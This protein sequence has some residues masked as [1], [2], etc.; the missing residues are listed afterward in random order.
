V[1]WGPARLG[2]CSD[3]I[4]VA[5]VIAFIAAPH[6]TPLVNRIV[7][8]VRVPWWA[9]PGDW[10]SVRLRPRLHRIGP[11]RQAAAAAR[12][13]RSPEK[14][15]E[16]ARPASSHGTGAIAVA[17]GSALPFLQPISGEGNLLAIALVL[18]MSASCL[19][20]LSW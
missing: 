5:I 3:R 6:L 11:A 12:S 13:T 2:R 16:A 8:T 15:A 17:V 9:L 20:S 7:G 19:R 14:N 10:F 1:G 18:T 4:V